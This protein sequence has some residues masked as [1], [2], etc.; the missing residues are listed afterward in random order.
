MPQLQEQLDSVDSI[1]DFCSPQL[2]LRLQEVQQ[3]VMEKWEELRLQAEQREEELK[4][5]RQRYLFLNTVSSALCSF[6]T[7]QCST[8]S[9]QQWNT[10]NPLFN[11]R[12]SCCAVFK[13]V[14]RLQVHDYLSW[15]GQLSG[16]MA[17]EE[18]ISDVATADLQLALHQQLRAEM[19]ARLETYQQ[20]LDMGEE[21]QGQDRTNRKE[22][23]TAGTDTRKNNF[24]SFCLCSVFCLCVQI[25][26][27]AVIVSCV[28]VRWG[29][30]CGACAQRGTDWSSSGATG[31]T[32]SRT[33][34]WSSCS[35]ETLIIWTRPRPLRRYPTPQSRTCTT[36]S[37]LTL[38]PVQVLLQN[39]SL[40]N[41]VDEIEG[42]IKR[43]EAFEKLLSSQDDKVKEATQDK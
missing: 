32:G 20:A 36:A 22:V 42:L 3:E 14:F 34:I 1:L 13:H 39:A 41:S 28:C 40:G 17:A 18:S 38:C 5:A 7:F 21:L 2:K 35:T 23:R 19:D 29:R 33:S 31:S 10:F 8:T 37:D 25:I 43:H 11:Y 24:T 9:I 12:Y 15:C 16:A 30:S 27:P 4:L 6:L 26:F